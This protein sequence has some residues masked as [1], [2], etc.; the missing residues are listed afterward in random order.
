LEHWWTFPHTPTEP[1]K[2]FV[3]YD[4]NG[5]EIFRIAGHLRQTRREAKRSASALESVAERK[6]P[7]A[8]GHS[9]LMGPKAT[10]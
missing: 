7:P 6:K 4:Q 9:G 8:A 5:V 2:R 10:E 1:K 3:L